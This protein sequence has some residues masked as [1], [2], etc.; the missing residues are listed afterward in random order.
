M[1]HPRFTASQVKSFF[2]KRLHI[3]KDG[4]SHHTVVFHDIDLPPSF[5][6]GLQ[7]LNGTQVHVVDAK[8]EAD[9]TR[10]L[11]DIR[12]EGESYLSIHD[13][14]SSTI[15]DQDK[16]ARDYIKKHSNGDYTCFEFPRTELDHGKSLELIARYVLSDP[17]EEQNFAD[18]FFNLLLTQPDYTVEI[19][20][21]P[22]REHRLTVIGTAPWME[23]CGPLLEGDLRFAPGSELFYNSTSVEGS[24]Y[25]AGALNLLP[26]RGM[27]LDEAYCQQLLDWGRRLPHEPIVM[28]LEKGTLLD[29]N[30][31]GKL[32]KDLAPLMFMPDYN[33]LVEVGIGL[34]RSAL[35]FIYDWASPSNEGAPGVHLGFG[36]DPGNILSAT[37]SIHMDFVNPDTEII[38]N[39]EQFFANGRFAAS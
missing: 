21:G 28:K 24:F 19:L 4:R 29:I 9:Q 30:G 34:M 33:T 13:F 17:I 35:P 26:I 37:T 1:T 10:L 3:P 23:L 20:S 5:L 22:D 39:G 11:N 7:A 18:A 16:N 31:T 38:V 2:E 27:D 25:C 12:A 14:L 36:A 8:K 32:C 6:S 15:Y